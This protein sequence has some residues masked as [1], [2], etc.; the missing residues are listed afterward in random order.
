MIIRINMLFIILGFVACARIVEPTS[1]FN[2][3]DPKSPGFHMPV[4]SA[5]FARGDTLLFEQDTFLNFEA[6]DANATKEHIAT[7][8]NCEGISDAR[9]EC[10]STDGSSL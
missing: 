3:A 10:R 8:Q 4:V 6:I 7:I 1:E 5:S 2:P 9:A